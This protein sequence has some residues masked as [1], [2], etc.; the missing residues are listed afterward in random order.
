MRGSSA[1]SDWAIQ[2]SA[3]SDITAGVNSVAGSPPAIPGRNTDSQVL[4][5]P[6]GRIRA[7]SS[8][9]DSAGDRK[10]WPDGS[11]AAGYMVSPPNQSYALAVIASSSARSPV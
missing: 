2:P 9:S 10:S 5:S 7:M 11:Q 4:N 8:A 6:L 1:G 3:G